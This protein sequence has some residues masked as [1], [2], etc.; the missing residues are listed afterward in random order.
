M[1]YGNRNINGISNADN[2]SGS[3]DSSNTTYALTD[4]GNGKKYDSKK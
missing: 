1:N 3:M 2:S 4:N